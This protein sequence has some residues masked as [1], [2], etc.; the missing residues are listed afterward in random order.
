MAP[1][2]IQP[3]LYDTELSRYFSPKDANRAVRKEDKGDRKRLFASFL[4][5]PTNVDDE[6]ALFG[7]RSSFETCPVTWSLIAISPSEVTQNGT[8]LA[9]HSANS[10]QI[11]SG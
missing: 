5:N 8:I 6:A 9:S 10:A 7:L 2:L 1:V 11:K 3:S 4:V